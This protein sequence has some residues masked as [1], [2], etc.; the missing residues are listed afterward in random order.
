MLAGATNVELQNEWGLGS[1]PT[2]GRMITTLPIWD[3]AP[4][5]QISAL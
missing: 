2:L 4:R 3:G 5:E 1:C